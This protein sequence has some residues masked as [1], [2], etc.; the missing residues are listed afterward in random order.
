MIETNDGLPFIGE[1]RRDQF[2][3]TGFAGNGMTFGTLAGDDG[4][5]RGTGPEEPVAGAVRPRPHE[6]RGGAWDYLKEN[7]DYP[8]YMMRDRIA[9]PDGARCGRCR[10]GE[11]KML[12]VDGERVAASAAPTA[13]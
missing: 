8:Y 12:D 7:V 10:R 4:A 5:R 2:A 1:T 6:G 3:A 9:G 11:G 13:A